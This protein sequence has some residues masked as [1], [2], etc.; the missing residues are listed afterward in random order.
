M[1]EALAD[2]L[3]F[4]VVLRYVMNASRVLR[5]QPPSPQQ[6]SVVLV[7]ARRWLLASVHATNV[8]LQHLEESTPEPETAELEVRRRQAETITVDLDLELLEPVDGG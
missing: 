5:V 1:D 6:Q 7:Q 4:D 8:L 3:G 2:G